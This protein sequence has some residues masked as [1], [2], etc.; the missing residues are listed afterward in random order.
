MLKSNKLALFSIATAIFITGC[1]HQNQVAVGDPRKVVVLDDTSYNLIDVKNPWFEKSGKKNIKL[2]KHITLSET[3][4]RLSRITGEDYILDGKNIE[5]PKSTNYTVKNFED[6]KYFVEH[7]TDYTIFKD[8]N[9]YVKGYPQTIAVIPKNIYMIY[10]KKMDIN[11]DDTVKESL[12][13]LA[14]KI[15]YNIIIRDDVPKDILESKNGFNGNNIYSFLQYANDKFG[16]FYK[17]DN[18]TNTLKITNINTT[19]RKLVLNDYDIEIIKPYTEVTVL[20]NLEND[21]KNIVPLNNEKKFVYNINRSMGSVSFTGNAR[22]TKEFEK[23]VQEFNDSYDKKIHLKITRYQFYPTDDM[24]VEYDAIKEK[25][26]QTGKVFDKEVYA[27]YGYLGYV[28]SDEFTLINNI[29]YNLEKVNI[30]N[31]VFSDKEGSIS[32]L[33]VLPVVNADAVMLKMSMNNKDFGINMD[34]K[35]TVGEDYEHYNTVNVN[36]SNLNVWLKENENVITNIHSDFVPWA[37]ASQ[38]IDGY[39]NGYIEDSTG[40]RVLREEILTMQVDILD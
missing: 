2:N 33:R 10:N 8:K 26:I 3:L 22:Q 15:G 19:T 9:R 24:R 32:K 28:S 17:V 29:P 1:S 30:K 7:V 34:S 27:K 20:D 5:L 31:G 38:T 37:V 39:I 14:D 21:I 35:P 40:K 12:K 13:K 4:E 6:L 25:L 23:I 18:T 11:P 36:N 16:F